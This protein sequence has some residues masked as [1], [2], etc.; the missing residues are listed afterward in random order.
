MSSLYTQEITSCVKALHAM[1]D[2]QRQ[3]ER[4][5]TKRGHQCYIKTALEAV[6]EC[7]KELQSSKMTEEVW[8]SVRGK[9]L[10]ELAEVWKSTHASMKTLQVAVDRT[11]A[12]ETLDAIDSEVRKR[13]CELCEKDKSSPKF[14]WTYDY[15]ASLLK[16][17]SPGTTCSFGKDYEVYWAM[18]TIEW[19][20]R[21]EGT[22]GTVPDTKLGLV[23]QMVERS[24]YPQ[25]MKEFIIKHTKEMQERIITA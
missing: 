4:R 9:D 19:Y 21:D 3:Y 22:S 15:K 2:L 1:E 7:L 23:V 18:E 17:Y 8:E 11:R 24:T 12:D 20:E 14:E 5:H 16:L 25:K 13:F 6:D 10:D